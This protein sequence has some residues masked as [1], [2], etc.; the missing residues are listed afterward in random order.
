[1]YISYKFIVCKVNIIKLFVQPYW[2]TQFPTVV[3]R[4]T[5]SRAALVNQTI[6]CIKCHLHLSGHVQKLTLWLTISTEQR[7]VSIIYRGR[8]VLFH[9]TQLRGYSVSKKVSELKEKHGGTSSLRV[10][11]GH[12]RYVKITSIFTKSIFFNFKKY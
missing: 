3:S 9:H 10:V 7:P 8:A 2:W 4:E 5:D 11:R 1:M 12:G 6:N